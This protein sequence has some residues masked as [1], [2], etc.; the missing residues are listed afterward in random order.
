MAR[1]SHARR[2]TARTSTTAAQVEACEQRILLAATVV[3]PNLAVRPAAEGLHSPVAIAFLGHNDFLVIEKNSGQ[4]KRVTAGEVQSTPVLDL[5]VNRALEQGLLGIEVH[6]EFAANPYV[7]LYWTESTTGQDSGVLSE[8]PLMGNR[9]DRFVWDGAALT[10]DR[11]LIRL[12]AAQPPNPRHE[13]V[14]FGGHVGG[15]IRF[16]PDGKL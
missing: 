8:T 12:R 4:V 6:P 13:S 3:D 2:C 1:S 16:G 10:Y 9:V 14:A 15:V 7:Y 11:T 5:P